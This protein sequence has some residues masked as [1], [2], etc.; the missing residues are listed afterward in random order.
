MT[1]VLIAFSGI[2]CIY[3]K[4]I[5]SRFSRQFHFQVLCFYLKYKQSLDAKINLATTLHIAYY[6]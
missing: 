5:P 4:I 6:P 2:Q 3:A 1:Q